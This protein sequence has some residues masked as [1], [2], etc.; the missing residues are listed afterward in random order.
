VKK[1]KIGIMEDVYCKESIQ[2]GSASAAR[3]NKSL[4]FFR[5]GRELLEKHEVG[6]RES[7]GRRDISIAQI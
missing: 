6:K 5:C 4:V 1:I 7:T 3:D 2:E